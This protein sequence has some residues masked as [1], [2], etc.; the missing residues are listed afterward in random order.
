[1]GETGTRPVIAHGNGHT[2]RWFFLSLI[3]ELRLLEH[4]GLQDEDLRQY[5][6]EGPVPPGTPVTEAVLKEYAPWWY[7]KDIHSGAT[8]GFANFRAIRDMQRR[9]LDV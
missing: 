5:K 3:N 2:G 4:L 8:D 9:A 6:H 7:H 1:M